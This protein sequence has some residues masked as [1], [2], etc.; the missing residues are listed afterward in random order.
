M[1]GWRKFI[2]CIVPIILSTELYIWYHLPGDVLSSIW[3][4]SILAYVGG[5]V[6]SKVSDKFGNKGDG[7]GDKPGV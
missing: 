6:G 5:N 7:N 1:I 4:I 3:E 2:F